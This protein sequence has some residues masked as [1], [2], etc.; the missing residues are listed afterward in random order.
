MCEVDCMVIVQVLQTLIESIG[1]YLTNCH[2]LHRKIETHSLVVSNFKPFR[3]LYPELICR[4]FYRK[5]NQ[6]WV[7]R[8]LVFSIIT[9]NEMKWNDHIPLKFMVKLTLI[10]TV[11]RAHRMDYKR[12]P[13]RENANHETSKTMKLKRNWRWSLGIW[14][15]RRRRFLPCEHHFPAALYYLNPLQWWI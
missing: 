6:N 9:S 14:Y 4:N 8:C 11:H 5:E 2:G 1:P 13:Y 12:H 7:L 3:S 10:A 15:L